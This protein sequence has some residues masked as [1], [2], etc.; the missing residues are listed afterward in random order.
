MSFLKGR[1]R[2]K[3]I[4][5]DY[6]VQ[7][8]GIANWIAASNVNP[9]FRFGGLVIF[10]Y[11]GSVSGV[12]VIS[13][14][15]ADMLT[16]T[17]GATLIS[18]MLLGGSLGTSPNTGFK[19]IPINFMDFSGDGGSNAIFYTLSATQALAGDDSIVVITPKKYAVSGPVT[20]ASVISVHFIAQGYIVSVPSVYR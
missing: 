4:D 8:G 6:T 12:G 18:N 7:G 5:E 1:F 2:P 11:A 10:S 20:S 9:D 13:E 19:V 14:S 3:S 17:Y 16:S 15:A